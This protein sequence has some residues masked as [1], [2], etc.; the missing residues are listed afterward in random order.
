MNTE[1]VPVQNLLEASWDQMIAD[2]TQ[3]KKMATKASILAPE[4]SEEYCEALGYIGLCHIYLGDY[5]E[6][7][8]VL[9]NALAIISRLNFSKNTRL[10]NNAL[11]MCYQALGRYGAALDH[12]EYT[13]QLARQSDDP[14]A[15]MPPLINMASLLFEMDHFDTAEQIITEVIGLDFTHALP[16]NVV[17]VNLLQ[18]QILLSSLRFDEAE[19]ALNQT[20]SLANDMG[21]QLAI[22]RCQ[23]LRGRLMRLRGQLPQAIALLTSIIQRE[24]LAAEG[25]DAVATYIELAKALYSERQIE[26]ALA[27]LHECLH[28]L[29]PPEHSPYRLRTL[30]QIAHGYHCQGDYE[31]EA[32]YLRLILQI[33]RSTT[34]KQTQNILELREFKRIQEEERLNQ[35]LIDR[36]NHLLKQ[37]RD[38]LSLLNDIAHQIT[39]TLNFQEVGH[40]LF[41]ILAKHMDVHFVSLLTL[42]EEKELLQF[43]FVIDSGHSI[44]A[45]DIPLSTPHSNSVKAITTQK[46][47]VIDDASQLSALNTIGDDETAPRSMLF[48]PLVLDDEILGVFSMQSQQAHRFKGDEVQLMVAICKFISIAVSNILSHERV[49]HLNRILF[50]EK[51][52]IENAQERIAHMA[53]HDS[54]TT[55]PNRQALEE[56]VEQRI[57]DQNRPF[58]LVYIDL[59]G[60]KPVNDEHGHRVGDKVL[61][62][63]AKRI[64]SALRSRDFAARVGGDEFVLIVDAFS[65]DAD[66]QG[67]LSRLLDVIETPIS[68]PPLSL[69]VSASIGSAQYPARGE[70]LDELMHHADIAMYEIKRGG[71]GGVKTF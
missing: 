56:F 50:T 62:E 71:K 2:P 36:E 27:I 25:T 24:E 11:G 7:S 29:S 48:V 23:T 10:V 12:F 33:E 34:A 21:Y 44:S 6:A 32:N 16:D 5:D 43:R 57:H 26:P 45:A 15:L 53:Y 47:V 42:H 35:I 22:L 41:K 20:E 31:Q 67:F 66:L 54:L 70:N 38:R 60:F 17:E 63:V 19:I 28:R 64:N 55:L 59:D 69:Q 39:M 68:L 52:A 65:N 51:Q 13:A 3:A 14:L 18:T 4:D 9:N 1:S 46:P 30:E 37:S 58:N 40:R 61:I 8:Q 49:K